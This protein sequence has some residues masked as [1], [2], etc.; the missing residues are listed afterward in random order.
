MLVSIKREPYFYLLKEK[1]GVLGQNLLQKEKMLL[2]FLQGHV[3]LKKS[4]KYNK[5]SDLS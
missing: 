4:L 2:K 1:I 3:N 5:K